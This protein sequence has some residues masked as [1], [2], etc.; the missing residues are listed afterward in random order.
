MQDGW[1]SA[2]TKRIPLGH[3]ESERNISRDN[4][5]AAMRPSAS[6]RCTDDVQA[7]TR[8]RHVVDKEPRINIAAIEPILYYDNERTCKSF[9]N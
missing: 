7:V 6:L 9:I 1:C 5:E 2:H 8:A 4:D 3:Q